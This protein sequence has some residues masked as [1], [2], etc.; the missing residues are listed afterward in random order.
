MICG[1]LDTWQMREN[2][3]MLLNF[4]SYFDVLMRN[5]KLFF[6][7]TRFDNNIKNKQK[8][9]RWIESKRARACF[10]IK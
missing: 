4:K 8:P 6:L 7:F 5:E 9:V 3:N 10:I 2:K 1:F